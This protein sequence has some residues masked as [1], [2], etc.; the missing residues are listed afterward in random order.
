MKAIIKRYFSMVEIALAIGIFAVGMATIATL[1][2][3]WMKPTK[4]SIGQNYSAVFAD[5]TYSY[6]SSLAKRGGTPSGWDT[7]SSMPSYNDLFN[8]NE[9]LKSNYVLSTTNG[10]S[11]I[12]GTAIYMRL[13]FGCLCDSKKYDF[14]WRGTE[15]YRTSIGMAERSRP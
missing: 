15:L 10:L 14:N 2:P 8:S 6:L 11:K 1:V 9:N 5:D 12:Q 3:V 4:D 13:I 7:I